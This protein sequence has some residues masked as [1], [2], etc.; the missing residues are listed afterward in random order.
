MAIEKGMKKLNEFVTSPQ[1]QI[2]KEKIDNLYATS[3]QNSF[4]SYKKN[5]FREQFHTTQDIFHKRKDLTNH[6]NDSLLTVKYSL[7]EKKNKER[8]QS[9]AYKSFGE[10][11]MINLSK[12]NYFEVKPSLNFEKPS[13]YKGYLTNQATVSPPIESNRFL[14]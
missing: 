7:T 8:M 10:S 1:K 11:Q 5:Q 3:L 13:R 9:L 4:Q 6:L 2:I 14:R 12:S